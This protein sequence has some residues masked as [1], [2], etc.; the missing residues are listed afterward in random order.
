MI[1]DNECLK[2]FYGFKGLRLKVN[3]H[4][5]LIRRIRTL[6]NLNPFMPED[7]IPSAVNTNILA[8]NKNN[9]GRALK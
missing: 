9:C 7:V 5:V 1:T 2:G 6:P 8:Y 3:F 4:S